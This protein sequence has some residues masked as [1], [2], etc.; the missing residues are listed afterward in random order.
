MAW[1]SNSIDSLG[2]Y[3]FLAFEDSSIVTCTISVSQSNLSGSARLI[4]LRLYLAAMLCSSLA[5]ILLESRIWDFISCDV[6]KA[7]SAASDE[8]LSS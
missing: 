7:L 4:N 8:F 5:K 2:M 1:S 6:F 3:S